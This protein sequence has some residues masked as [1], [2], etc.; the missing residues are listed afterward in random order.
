V[1]PTYVT[2][3]QI[4]PYSAFFDR[5]FLTAFGHVHW[6]MTARYTSTIAFCCANPLHVPEIG[7]DDVPSEGATPTASGL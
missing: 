3:D 1:I 6:S 4:T 7:V 5:S 2:R